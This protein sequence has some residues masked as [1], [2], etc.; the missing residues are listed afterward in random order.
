MYSTDAT[1][2]AREWH[3]HH[4][5]TRALGGVGLVIVEATAVQSRGRITDRDLGIWSDDHIAG[6]SEIVKRIKKHGA[7]AGIQL[8]HAGRKCTVKS[9]NIIAPSPLIFDPKDPSYSVPSEMDR[10][11]ME[12]IITAFREAA[13]RARD[14]GFDFVEVHGAHGYLLNEFLTPLVNKRSDDFGGTPENRS[15]LVKEVVQAVRQEWTS[16]KP[17]ALRVSA[18]DYANG[19]NEPEDLAVMINLVKKAGIDL[20]HVSSGGVVPDAVIEA[21]PG[22]QIPAATLIR[23]RTNLPVMGGGLIS[24]PRQADEIIRNCRSDMVFLG[25]ELLRNPYWA[26][27]AAKE[28]KQPLDYRPIPYERAYL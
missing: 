20:I 7:A 28:L 11:D 2:M 12:G 15:R 14:A 19:G 9:E 16:E 18:R 10:E 6:L 23:E 17:L 24:A 26:Y 4:Y 13:G 27:G 8:A 25:R 21:F 1:G 22:F 5:E 3:F